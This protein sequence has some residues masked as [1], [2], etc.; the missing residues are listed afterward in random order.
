MTHE[1]KKPTKEQ[2]DKA[3]EKSINENS[4]VLKRLE[5]DDAG[6]FTGALDATVKLSSDVK[7]CDLATTDDKSTT[8]GQNFTCGFKIIPNTSEPIQ[9]GLS[10]LT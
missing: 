3:V 5:D 6:I 7:L 2:I 9:Y 10:V 1:V 4:K 8:E